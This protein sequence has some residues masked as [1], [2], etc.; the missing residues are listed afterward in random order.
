[1]LVHWTDSPPDRVGYWMIAIK[2]EDFKQLLPFL[3]DV[4]NDVDGNLCFRCEFF[5]DSNF[6]FLLD[7]IVKNIVKTKF[8]IVEK[9]KFSISPLQIKNINWDYKYVK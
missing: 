6:P 2:L 8:G 5:Y 9:I 1:M 4:F 7:D 3:V